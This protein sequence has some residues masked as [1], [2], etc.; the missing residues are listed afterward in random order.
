M[1]SAVVSIL[2]HFGVGLALGSSPLG[3]WIA[4]AGGLVGDLRIPVLLGVAVML[5]VAGFDVVYACQ[6]VEADRRLGLHSIPARLGIPRA[7]GIAALLHAL[8]LA[9]FAAFRPLA[10]LGWFYG[11]AVV[12]AGALLAV[13]H[14]IVSPSDLRRVNVAFFNLNGIVALLLGA[15]GIAD[16]LLA[17]GA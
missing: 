11:G 16:V 15:G 4:G 8:C 9:A 2:A 17:V 12:L 1:V 5:W 13:E 6:D 3:A 14:A 10:G 7:L